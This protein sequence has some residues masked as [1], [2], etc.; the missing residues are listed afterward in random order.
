VNGTDF[1]DYYDIL[2]LSQNA[3]ADTIEHVHRL[4]V[5]RYHPDNQSTGDAEKFKEVQHAYEFLSNPEK[6]A[7]Y[8]IK[9]DENRKNLWR[10]F[11]RDSATDAREEDRRIVHGILSL[12][13]VARRRDVGNPGMGPIHLENIL[14]CPQQHMEFHIWYL[15]QK[16][17]IETLSNG[18]LA[19]TAD[20]VDKLGDQ[21]LALRKDRLLSKSSVSGTESPD[22]RGEKSLSDKVFIEFEGEV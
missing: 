14:G 11:D 15:K 4:L 1:V 3:S 5:R 9:Y 22:S 7:A 16:G 2:Q 10:I 20:G 21:D 19:L 18:Q 8:D 17:W 12:L 6:R 13:Y